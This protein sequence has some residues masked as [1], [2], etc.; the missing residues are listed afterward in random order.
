M[1]E[2]EKD[3]LT[4]ETPECKKNEVINKKEYEF[5][6]DNK[7]YELIVSINEETIFNFI[8]KPRN[9]K[10]INIIEYYEQNKKLTELFELFFI[11]KDENKN[12][13]NVIFERI[14]NFI[15]KKEIS[16]SKKNDTI[17]LTFLFKTQFDDIKREIGLEKKEI[18]ITND[19]KFDILNKKIVDLK[20]EFN[21]IKNYY[22]KQREENNNEIKI[23][24]E[25][26]EKLGINKSDN[27]IKK[28][29]YNIVNELFKSHTASK[30]YSSKKILNEIDGEIGV[31]DLFEVYHLHNEE[32]IVY[33]ASKRKRGKGDISNI[34][35]FALFSINDI[36]KIK[37]LVGHQNQIVFVKYFFNPKEVK[38]Y[39]LSGDVSDK[40]IVWDILNDY[41]KV[42][43]INVEYKKLL[44]DK[45]IYNSLLLFTEKKN[46]I[47]T[48]TYTN[49]NSKLY[50]LEDAAFIKDVSITYNYKTLYMLK[51][52]YKS[53]DKNLDL[54]IDCCN[55]FVV[56]YNPF[57]EEI[58]AEINNEKTIGENRYA[59]ITY[60]KDNKEFLSISNER[61]YIVIYDLQ[62]KYIFK[63]FNLKDELYSIINWKND[64]LICSQN[65]F[66]RIIDIKEK[67]ISNFI[68]CE[69]N[70]ICIKYIVL[71]QKDELIIAAGA[72]SS[73][74]FILFSPSS[75]T[76]KGDEI[77]FI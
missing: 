13:N 14:D 75:I 73:N 29:K 52:E 66:L 25:K 21:N 40:I 71:N 17:Y 70:I 48:S 46:Y 54:I 42:C 27:E 50:E 74:I 4:I 6:F 59:C 51:Y 57:N 24:K 23:L 72:N 41:E 68:E 37:I 63:Y 65:N 62:K 35:I 61:G 34:S 1:E 55:N 19:K 16:L 76:N 38:E 18:K 56:I 33:I 77:S 31:N 26:I 10:N 15:N 28:K 44:I 11:I 8:L 64:Y 2:N 22:E 69:K 3:I 36:F 43:F 30:I 67:S 7:N 53:K 47:Y 9:P 60:D 12:Q 58:Y 39:L 20:N 5:S 32:N 45:P 49:N